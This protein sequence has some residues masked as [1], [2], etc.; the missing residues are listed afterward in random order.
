MGVCARACVCV[1][2]CVCMKTTSDAPT[3]I[4]VLVENDARLRS[5][6]R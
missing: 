5:E 4:P 1:C 3:V 6:N 2:V